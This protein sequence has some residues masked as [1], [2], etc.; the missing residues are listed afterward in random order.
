[1]LRFIVDNVLHPKKDLEFFGDIIIENQSFQRH[2][3]LS[4]HF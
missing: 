4:N 3:T 2:S 1:M